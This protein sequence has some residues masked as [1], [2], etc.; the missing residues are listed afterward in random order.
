MMRASM[1]KF[2]SVTATR[3]GLITCQ[4]IRT[5][6]NLLATVAFTKQHWYPL[7][8]GTDFRLGNTY[9]R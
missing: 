4:F 6:I 2:F 3:N 1:T 9:N 8:V 7:S 5:N